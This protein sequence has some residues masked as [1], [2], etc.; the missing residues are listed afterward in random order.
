MPFVRF[1]SVPPGEAPLNVRRA[2][3]GL[4]VPLDT[5]FGNQPRQVSVFGVVTGPRDLLVRLWDVLTGKAPKVDGFIL[6]ARQCVD[7]L[8]GKDPKAAAW[9]R[10]NA[11]HMLAPGKFFVFAADACE[12]LDAD[13]TA[14]PLH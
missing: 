13:P 12:V 2:W 4:V 1:I 6:P 5:R 7:L 3:V 14:A 9:W 11:P 10:E 8:E